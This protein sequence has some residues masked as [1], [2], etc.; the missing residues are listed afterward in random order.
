[1]VPPAATVSASEAVCVLEPEVPV[2][3]IVAFAAAAAE[4]ALRF[5]C[6]GVPAVSVKV[7][8]ETVTPDGA[9]ANDTVTVPEKPD[10]PT[11]VTL[12]AC[13][14]PPAVRLAVA[15]LAVKEK[16]GVTDGLPAL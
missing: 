5:T 12:T 15:G 6:C 4:L 1:V 11:A 8:G 14:A 16:S 2:K 7:A 10:T 9:P 3:T 13:A